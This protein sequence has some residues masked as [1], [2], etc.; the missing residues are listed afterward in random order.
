MIYYDKKLWELDVFRRQPNAN[1]G[2]ELETVSVNCLEKGGKGEPLQ[3]PLQ[4]PLH[5]W[6]VTS[7]ACATLSLS[8]QLCAYT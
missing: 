4:E 1:T 7:C 8:L 6:Y 3:E 5:L 2:A